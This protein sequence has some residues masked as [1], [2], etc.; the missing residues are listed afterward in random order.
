MLRMDRMPSRKFFILPAPTGLENRQG[1]RALDQ[2]PCAA[3]GESDLEKALHRLA[4]LQDRVVHVMIQRPPVTVG[5]EAREAWIA[6]PP[7]RIPP[8]SKPDG[9]TMAEIQQEAE[10]ISVTTV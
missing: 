10:H 8:K 9:R 1:V 5:H 7:S 2:N 6:K 4:P 3:Q